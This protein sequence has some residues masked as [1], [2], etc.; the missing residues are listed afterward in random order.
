MAERSDGVK[1]RILRQTDLDRI[2]KID[3]ALTGRNRRTWL[4][5]KLQRALAAADVNISLG[6]EV[7][8]MLV[9]CVLG[10]VHFGEFGQPEPVAV[11][12]TILVDPGFGRRGV[13]RALVAQLVRNL[14]AL[15]IER[16]RTEV[17]WTEQELISFMARIGFAPAPR[18]VLEL[19]VQEASE[20]LAGDEDGVDRD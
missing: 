4:E 5:G 14:A 13:G 17:S 3:Q 16:V 1:V 20:R 10:A 11:L 19:D 2:V 8:S 15:R 9:G 7:D 12:D 18:L 6:A